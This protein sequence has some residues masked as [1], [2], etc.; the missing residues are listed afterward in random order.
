M[1]PSSRQPERWEQTLS[2]RVRTLA[3]TGPIHRLEASKANRERDLERHDLRALALRAIDSAIEHMGL[4]YGASRQ[5]LHQALEPLIRMAEPALGGRDVAEI[6]DA[7]IEHLLNEQSRRRA[8]DEPYLSFDGPT[9]TMRSVSFHLLREEEADDGTIVLKATTEAINFYAGMLEVDIEDAQTAAEAVLR[10]QLE[11]GAIGAAVATARQARLRSIEYAEQLRSTLRQ[12]RRDVT[13]VEAQRMLSTIASARRHLEER[14]Q[15][16]RG[17]LD[18]VEERVA[19]AD[20]LDASS[21]VELRDALSDCRQRHLKLHEEL[22]TI[23]ETWLAEQELQRFRRAR[24]SALPDLESDVFQPLV[25]QTVA[26]AAPL[27]EELVPSL[28]GPSAPTVMDVAT[29]AAHLLAP[30]RREAEQDLAP[31]ADSLE[32]ISALEVRFPP[33]IRTAVEQWL[34]RGGTLGDLLKASRRAGEPPAVRRLLVLRLLWAWDPDG[35][36]PFS[37][38]TYGRLSDPEYAGQDLRLGAGR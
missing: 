36:E 12:V 9:A 29:L 14:L 10:A 7:V 21:L 11:R 22:L 1:V 30:R 32:L 38:Q 16:E 18:T 20:E 31:P 15:V 2:R 35:R 17:L 33:E 25:A 27:L 3:R 23:T 5:H 34:A 24:P 13:R 6:A 8:F 37:V 4:G 19:T 26:V 28:H